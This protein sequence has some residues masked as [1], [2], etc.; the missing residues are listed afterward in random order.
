[1]LGPRPGM[2]WGPKAPADV[3][4]QLCEGSSP[5]ALLVAGLGWPHG[6][7]P[8]GISVENVLLVSP[9]MGMHKVVCLSQ[10]FS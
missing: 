5:E 9:A 1:M 2:P 7:C 3:A 10:V 8:A 4:R 6:A